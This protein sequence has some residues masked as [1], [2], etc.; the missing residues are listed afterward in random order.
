MAV[1]VGFITTTCAVSESTSGRE[2]RVIRPMLAASGIGDRHA[3]IVRKRSASVRTFF[4]LPFCTAITGCWRT[5]RQHLANDI[6]LARIRDAAFVGGE[7]KVAALRDAQFGEKRAGA[8][9]LEIY[10]HAGLATVLRGDLLDRFL[11]V[12]GAILS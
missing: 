12:G 3:H 1:T 8:A 7:E 9:I 11:Q 2:R 4:G 10:F 5:R 6:E